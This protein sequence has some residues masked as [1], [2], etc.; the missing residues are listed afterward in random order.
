MTAVS[1]QSQQQP[2]LRTRGVGK[3]FGKFVALNNISAEF[4][5]GA[6]TSII[7][8]NGAGKSTYFNLLSGALRPSSGSV[9]FEG[10]DVT[11]LAQHQFAHLGV[12]K[13][14]QITNV[15]PQ[16]STRENIRIGLQALVSRYDMWR[17]RARHTELIEQADELLNLVGLWESR[18]RTAKTLAHGEQRALEIG[19]ALASRPR[20]LLLDE[21]TAGMSPEE[22]RTMM[23]LIVK[24]ASERTVIVVEHKMK[25]VL[26]IS[27]RILVLH[28]GELLAEGTPLEVR[29]NEAVKRVYLGQKEH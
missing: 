23:D 27:D 6:I 3:T 10:R 11:G 9:E 21:P 25:L 12:A 24:L 17:P 15:F 4:T 2:I 16:L 13:S 22:T 26:G 1:A 7:G 5:K 8:P 29:Q 14:F 19:M 20:L 28:H 18:E